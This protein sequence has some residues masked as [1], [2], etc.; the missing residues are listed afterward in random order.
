MTH[1]PDQRDEAPSSIETPRDELS[2]EEAL[3]TRNA[4]DQKQWKEQLLQSF[5]TRELSDEEV[6]QLV[7]RAMTVKE[8]AAIE[9]LQTYHSRRRERGLSDSEDDLLDKQ[10]EE[11]QQAVQSL[12]ENLKT[13][14]SQVESSQQ[15]EQQLTA[16]DAVGSSSA[17]T[18]RLEELGRALSDLQRNR[19]SVQKQ[20][21]SLGGMFGSLLK[22]DS[23]KE[24]DLQLAEADRKIE[25]TNTQLEA[26]VSERRKLEKERDQLFTKRNQTLRGVNESVLPRIEEVKA[27]MQSLQRE[28]TNLQHEA[29]QDGFESLRKHAKFYQSSLER[30]T[31][32]TSKQPRVTRE[33]VLEQVNQF[34]DN[35]KSSKRS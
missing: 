15:L 2:H 22:T 5:K 27:G 12:Q 3:L 11:K 28:I 34:L 16:L 14:M 26:V 1:R 9:D 10:L 35:A 23:A 21:S 33:Q 17:T 20:K 31:A 19:A 29:A 13:L 8:Q 18:R 25:E 32:D 6:S 24:I 7:E 30:T 4:T